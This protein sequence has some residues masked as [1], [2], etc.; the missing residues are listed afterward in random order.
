MA[1]QAPKCSASGYAIPKYCK[2]FCN[3]AIVQFYLLSPLSHFLC[4]LPSLFLIFSLLS[5]DPNTILLPTSTSH[6]TVAYFFWWVAIRRVLWLPFFS[7]HGWRCGSL[8]WLW[9]LVWIIVVVVVFGMV[10]VV[11]VVFFFFFCLFAVT[12]A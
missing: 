10:T 12:S 5:S 11:V 6:I 8:W 3:T 9:F 4:S 2:F 1:F 7:W